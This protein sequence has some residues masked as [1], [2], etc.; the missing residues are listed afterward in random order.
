MRRL[1]ELTS[2]EPERSVCYRAQSREE[3]GVTIGLEDTPNKGP[4]FM[5]Y[6]RV[7]TE[8]VLKLR[9]RRKIPDHEVGARWS[10][11][12]GERIIC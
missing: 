5:G 8:P 2:R 10:H 7:W 9:V 1:R 3:G 12:R 11:A 4:L 6:A